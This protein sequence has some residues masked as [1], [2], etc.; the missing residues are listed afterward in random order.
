MTNEPIIIAPAVAE[1]LRYTADGRV[2]CRWPDGR[3]VEVIEK[4]AAEPDKTDCYHPINAVKN[5]SGL[6][7]CGLCGTTLA[8]VS[9]P[10]T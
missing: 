1:Y 3:F 6:V 4:P 2:F 5:L 9:T 7:I 8:D 10:R